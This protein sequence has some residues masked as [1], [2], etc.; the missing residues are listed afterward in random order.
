MYEMFA[1]WTFQ[2]SEILNFGDF[3][4]CVKGD[5]VA[6]NGIK[7]YVGTAFQNAQLYNLLT[8]GLLKRA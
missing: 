5:I 4:F 8:A 3:A 6:V 2:K 7:G 1:S